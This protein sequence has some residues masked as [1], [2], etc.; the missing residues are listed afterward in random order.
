[1]SFGSSIAFLFLFQISYY[2]WFG[3]EVSLL[4]S[5]PPSKVLSLQIPEYPQHH[6]KQLVSLTTIK[7]PNSMR[8]ILGKTRKQWLFYSVTGWTSVLQTR[9]LSEDIR[10]VHSPRSVVGKSL[11]I[12]IL[13]SMSLSTFVN[14]IT[15]SHG[16]ALSPLPFYFQGKH[17]ICQQQ[18]Q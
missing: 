1:M 13:P 14:L 15:L 8:L 9:I 18:Q 3:V 12:I 11:D 4:L 5:G 6:L 7:N 2:L 10:Q 17:F 16:K